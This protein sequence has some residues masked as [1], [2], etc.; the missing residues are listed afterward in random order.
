[1][2][3]VSNKITALNG[4]YAKHLQ[5]FLPYPETEKKEQKENWHGTEII[6]KYAWLENDGTDV[7]NWAKTQNFLTR[8][9]LDTVPDREKVKEE[10]KKYYELRGIG[11]PWIANNKQFQWRREGTQNHAILHMKDLGNHKEEVL[12]DPN[13]LSEDGTISVDWISISKNSKYLAYGVSEGGTEKSLLKIKDIENRTHLQDEIPY[14][15]ACSIGWLDDSGF[16]YTR[17]PEPESVPKGEE[18]YHRTIYFHKVGTSYKDDPVIF[19][20]KD[21]YKDW[22]NV[23]ISDDGKYMTISVSRGWSANDVYISNLQEPNNTKP[24]FLGNDNKL[25]AIIHQD[26]VYMLTNFGAPNGKVMRV[27]LNEP[28]ISDINKWEEIIPQKENILD[29]FYIIGGKLVL[30]YLEKAHSKLEVVDLSINKTEEI[31][32]PTIG[33]ILAINGNKQDKQMFYS[34]NSFAYP[35]E[36]RKVDIDTLKQE[37]IDRSIFNEDLSNIETKQITFNSKDGTNV[38]MFLVHK[39]DIKLDGENKVLLSGY[40]GFNISETPGFSKSIMPW[41]NQGGIYAIANLRGGGEYGENWHR[42]GMLDKKQNVFD[43]FISGAEYLIQNGYTKPNK[44]AIWGGSNGGLLVGAALVQRP[45]LF[46]AVICEVPLLDMIHYDR[47][48]IAKLWR[49]E[50]GDPSN[51]DHFEFLLKYSPYHNVH[52]DTQYPPTI[53]RTADGDSRV[54]PMHAKKMTAKLQSAN[55][56][57]N[58]ILLSVEEKAGHGAGKPLSKM[59]DDMAD[60]YA[61]LNS[62][63][64]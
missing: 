7:E 49:S 59:L 34:F 9:F 1:M 23:S 10:L 47:T 55:T 45:D 35:V 40:G 60:I 28:N 8:Q 37:Q 58:P 54:D 27:P 39:K 29:D 22:P 52:E 36:I 2:S 31:T 21:A 42:A 19:K 3:T 32:L 50:Y 26:N 16:Y 11:C 13:T 6:D 56:S 62:V 43:D 63:L 24:L 57:N 64:K 48:K 15:R 44:L 33:S 5:K 25:S 18:N 4:F 20:P 30:H 61:F 53:I 46:G 17:Y 38:T 41:I 51:P 12:L 14:T